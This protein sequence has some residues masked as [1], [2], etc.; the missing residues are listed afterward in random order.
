MK[1]IK[2]SKLVL[3]SLCVFHMTHASAEDLQRQGPAPTVLEERN[4][5]PDHHGHQAPPE[6]DPIAKPA[7]YSIDGFKA[8][9]VY[10]APYDP[11]EQYIVYGGK[12][13]ID[14][15]R[16]VIEW[17][18]PMY[19]E[20][21][22]GPG[23]N[24][25]GRK[26]LVRPQF[27]V[28]GDMRT[29]LASNDNGAVENAQLATQLNLDFDLNLT[30]TERLHMFVKPLDDG[31]Q[32]RLELGGS[33]VDAIDGNGFHGEYDFDPETFFFEGDWGAIQSGFQDEYTKFDLPIALGLMPLFL[34]N[35]LWINDAFV[36]G[37]VS[38]AAKNSPKYDITNYDITFMTGL[39]KVSSPVFVTDGALD[40][41]AGKFYGITTFV[42][43]AEGYFE[44]GFARVTDDR[45]DFGMDYN[46]VMLAWTKRY[47][48][49][50]SNSIR[51][52]YNFG[53]DPV[54][55]Q[56]Q[57]ADGYAILVENSWITSLPSTFVP[58][59]NFFVGKDRPQTLATGAAGVLRNTGINFET[60][61]VTGFPKLDDSANDTY[62][63]AIGIMNLF[64]LNQ[65]L[66]IEYANLQIIG[67]E[68]D[69]LRNAAAEQQAVGVRYQKPISR[70][71]IFRTDA[72]YGDRK[73]AD[74]VAGV[75]VEFR[76]KF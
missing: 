32:T 42:D 13:A 57:T 36:G 58:Y 18:Y 1:I 73:N 25:I 10:T 8:D 48:G 70:R 5:S 49:K 55:G 69:P 44:G 47:K 26:N 30:A 3:L 34:Q 7:E 64:S 40:D 72:M 74:D 4:S 15:P 50:L 33:P 16:P 67:D 76:C 68:N 53:Q 19:S 75:R 29:V 43:V 61:G 14:E 51:V 23:R 2:I 41:N 56:A 12:T 31:K 21:P 66:V 17:G 28:Y 11:E 63:G 54:A 35:G 9:P 27:L 38:I 71:W 65:Q 59:F 39:N 22:F 24:I 45:D 60:D 20:G 62:G 52:L 37:A 46:N 6:M